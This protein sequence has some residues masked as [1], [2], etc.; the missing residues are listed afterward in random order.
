MPVKLLMSRKDYM[1]SGIH[2]GTKSK[3][4][5]MKEFIYRIRPSGLAVMNITKI[6]ERIRIAARFLARAKRIMVVGKK[7]PVEKGLKKFGE[8]IGAEV[9]TKRFLPGTLT[10]PSFENYKEIDVMFI[11]DPLVDYQALEEAVKARVPIVAVCNTFNETKNIDLVIPAN[12]KGKRA[13]ATLLWLLARQ[14]LKERGVIKS[15]REFEYKIED[16]EK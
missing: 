9:I 16:F 13:L 1:S 8:I 12:N 5:D 14:I 3:T 7:T 6:D 2:I 10:N 4:K 11:I 15:D